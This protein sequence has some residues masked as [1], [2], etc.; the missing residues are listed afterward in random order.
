[1]KFN[2]KSVLAAALI[3]TVLLIAASCDKGSAEETTGGTKARQTTRE[4]ETAITVKPLSDYAIMG[5]EFTD[6]FPFE[7]FYV[8]D[9]YDSV[10]NKQQ[11]LSALSTENDKSVRVKVTGFL[12]E[13]LE[14]IEFMNYNQSYYSVEITDTFQYDTGY[15]LSKEYYILYNGSPQIQYFR[16]PTLEIGKEYILLFAGSYNENNPEELTGT[17]WL[18]IGKIDGIE[19]VYPYFIDC[20][21]LENSIPITDPAEAEI[22]TDPAVIKYMDENGIERP[23]FEYKFELNDFISQIK[24]MRE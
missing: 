13:K 7:K 2:I 18:K 6:V 4:T 20:C 22:Y 8:T 14:N 21:E 3:S 12:P 10:H 15:D 23:K 19:Y 9:G 17:F 5:P 16:A 24:A 11:K 1:M